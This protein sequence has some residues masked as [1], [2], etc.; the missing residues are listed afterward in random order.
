P[1]VIGKSKEAFDRFVD[2]SAWPEFVARQ[3]LETLV[4]CL[5]LTVQSISSGVTA[6]PTEKPST[7]SPFV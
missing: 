1:P 3:T 4:C 6:S 5:E 7:F 2:A